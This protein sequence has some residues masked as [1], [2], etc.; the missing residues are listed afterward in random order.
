MAVGFRTLLADAVA[1]Q[2]PTQLVA[3][4]I[5]NRDYE[6]E[7]KLQA[8]QS[9]VVNVVGAPTVQDATGNIDYTTGSTDTVVV[10][11]DQFKAAPDRISDLEKLQS[12]AGL[13]QGRVDASVRALANDEDSY[14]IGKIVAGVTAANTIGTVAAPVDCTT[15]NKAMGVLRNL[16]TKCDKNDIPLDG[17]VVVCPPEFENMLLSDTSAANALAATITEKDE[18]AVAVGYIGKLLGFRIFRSNNINGSTVLATHSVL[19]TMIDQFNGIKWFTDKDSP[20]VEFF[21]PLNLYGAG[22]VVPV[23][24]KAIVSFQ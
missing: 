3:N 17:R 14:V 12:S 20:T 13:R 23:S 21:S 15:F 11:I 5:A 16:K 18:S 7:A 6:D 9:V 22:V 2:L 10:N 24:A 19:N 8:G 4:Y 1:T